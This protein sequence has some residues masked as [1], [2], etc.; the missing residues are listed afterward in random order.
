[1]YYVYILYSP[2]SGKTYTGF[3]NDIRR[4]VT[5]HNATEAKGFTLRYRPWELIFTECFE[6]KQEAMSRENFF[7]SGQ[8]REKI[9]SIIK[10]YLNERQVRYPP[11]AEKD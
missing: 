1:M 5:E 7:K 4:R 2:S 11:E 10:D 8:G 6:T 9:K 3:S